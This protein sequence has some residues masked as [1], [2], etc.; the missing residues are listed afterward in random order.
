MQAP[1]PAEHPAFS[2]YLACLLMHAYQNRE[3]PGTPL[4]GYVEWALQNSHPHSMA[5]LPAPTPAPTQDI[6]TGP[7]SSNITDCLSTFNQPQCTQ[8][9]AV[10]ASVAA[11]AVGGSAGHT[12]GK[13]LPLVV[14][15]SG[16][17]WALW[18]PHWHFSDK[19]TG[20]IVGAAAPTTPTAVII[21]TVPM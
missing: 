5:D 14:S 17:Y 12:K 4:E 1:P 3:H 11:I 21:T 2:T 9:A 8:N 15:P 18:P 19:A 16:K 10:V 6:V 13:Q 20:G 7:P